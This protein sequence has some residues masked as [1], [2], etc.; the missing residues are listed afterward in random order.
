MTPD[1]L[2]KL[3]EAFLSGHTDE[4]ACLIAGID[5]STLYRYCQEN[6]HY[7]RKKELLKLRP[8]SQARH[9]I[10]KKINE[11]DAETSKW[12]LERKAKHE[13]STKQEVSNEIST[14]ADNMEEMARAM[15]EIA[16]SSR[17]QEHS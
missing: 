2:A 12:Y 16:E 7:A 3:D 5:P 6:E 15:R 13:F 4:E 8:Q 10:V 1:V 9:N 11:G 17:L 14:K